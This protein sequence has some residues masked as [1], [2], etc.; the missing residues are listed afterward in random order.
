MCSCSCSFS[1]GHVTLLGDSSGRGRYGGLVGLLQ[2]LDRSF[3]KAQG[4]F[5]EDTVYVCGEPRVDSASSEVCVVLSIH[6]LLLNA[7]RQTCFGLPT[8]VQTDTTHR[9]VIEGHCV[10]PIT[11]VD[12]LQHTHVIAYGIVSGESGTHACH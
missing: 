4:A 3:L 12:C 7:Y 10:M 5:H 9:L 2:H 11:T 6:N 1:Q 8:Y